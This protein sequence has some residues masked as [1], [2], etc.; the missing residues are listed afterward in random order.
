VN[1]MPQHQS[2]KADTE[3]TQSEIDDKNSFMMSP[4]A[5]HPNGYAEAA[6]SQRYEMHGT[7]AALPPVELPTPYNNGSRAHDFANS[8]AGFVSS[9][10]ASTAPSPYAFPSPSPQGSPQNSPSEAPSPPMGAITHRP[11]HNRNPS[12]IS[13]GPDLSSPDTVVSPEENMRQ[14]RILE[15]LPPHSSPTGPKQSSFGEMLDERDED[16]HRTK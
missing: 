4:T 16:E 6:G 9:R 3:I 11:G 13:S 1:G 5:D 10:E 8:P 2:Q 14:S 7:S 15:G 12:S